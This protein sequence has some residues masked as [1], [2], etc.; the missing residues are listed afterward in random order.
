MHLKTSIKIE[1]IKIAPEEKVQIMFSSFIPEI[2]NWRPRVYTRNSSDVS[3]VEELQSARARQVW[4]FEIS[5]MTIN[6]MSTRYSVCKKSSLV[7]KKGL[8]AGMCSQGKPRARRESKKKEVPYGGR[9]KLRGG[10]GIT[11]E[12]VL[13]GFGRPPTC[14]SSS[15]WPF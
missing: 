12:F 2:R 1:D 5:L 11:I 7:K 15:Y 10:A 4:G 9:R 3:S 8:Q 13:Q 14:E 6:K